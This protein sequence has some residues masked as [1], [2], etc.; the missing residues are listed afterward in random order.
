M[1][2][3][4]QVLSIDKINTVFHATEQMDSHILEH[5]IQ[6]EFRVALN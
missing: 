4:I 3:K 1:N 6:V 2:F 5:C